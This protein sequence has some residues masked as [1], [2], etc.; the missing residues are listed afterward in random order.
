MPENGVFPLVIMPITACSGLVL[1]TLQERIYR[2]KKVLT[3]MTYGV[4]VCVLFG[5]VSAFCQGVIPMTEAPKVAA[6]NAPVVAAEQHPLI[7]VIRWAEKEKPNAAAIKDYTA[8]MLKQENINGVVQEAQGMDIKIRHQPFSVYVKVQFPRSLAGQQEIYVKGQNDDKVFCHG[9][10]VERLLGTQKLDP[11]SFILMRGNKYPITDI[12]MVNLID[13]LLEVGYKDIKFGECTVTYTPEVK[14]NGR[15]CTMIRVV[16][17]VPRPHFR[18]HEALIYV[19]RE[20][21]LPIRYESNDWPRK[22][23]EKPKLIEAYT[24]LNIKT[25]VGLTDADFDHK[26]PAYNYPGVR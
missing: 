5:G 18:F 3:G 21:N 22:E 20:L 9:V 12:G 23:G 2:M 16:H 4:A 10:G 1:S 25:N 6:G 24:Y 7:P 11:D 8:T 15:E 17:P 19:D 13:K 26:N 14:V